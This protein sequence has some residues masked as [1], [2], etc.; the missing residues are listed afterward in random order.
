MIT[1]QEAENSSDV[2]AGTFSINSILVKVLFD[3]GATYSFISKGILEKLGLKEP[4]E[5][6]VPIVIPTGEIVKCTK[7]HR[8]VPLTIAK[9]IFLSSLIEFEL[10]D[11][12]VILGMD[13]LAMFKAKIDCEKQKI[14]LKSS[15]GKVVS[16]RRFGKPRSVGIVT[17]M[18]LMKLIHKGNPVFLCNVRDLDHVMKEQPGDIAVVSEFMDVF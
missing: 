17:A 1:R 5:I 4:E 2:I 13:W 14:H 12:D 10:G 11:L 6:E 3:S 8:N 9:T 18:E 7:I 15:L 16:Y